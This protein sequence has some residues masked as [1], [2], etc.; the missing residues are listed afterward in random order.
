MAIAERSSS[1]EG[2]VGIGFR[3]DTVDLHR[4]THAEARALDRLRWA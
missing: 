3:E 2:W 1:A 4:D